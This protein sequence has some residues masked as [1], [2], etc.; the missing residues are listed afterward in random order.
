M[1]GET[2]QVSHRIFHGTCIPLEE[3]LNNLCVMLQVK[4]REK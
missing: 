4:G 2:I 1:H 3:V